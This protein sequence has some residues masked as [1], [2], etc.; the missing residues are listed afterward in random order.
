MT[1]ELLQDKIKLIRE[2]LDEVAAEGV[3]VSVNNL[4]DIHG[5]RKIHANFRKVVH[6]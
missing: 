2:L 1:E 6:L 3:L 4:E 5:D